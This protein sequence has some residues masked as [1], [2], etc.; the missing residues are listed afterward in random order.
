LGAPPSDS[1]RNCG[2][3]GFGAA[4]VAAASAPPSAERLPGGGLGAAGLL[5]FTAGMAAGFPCG[6]GCGCSK[7]ERPASPRL[8]LPR[9]RLGAMASAAARTPPSG[10]PLLPTLAALAVR[11]SGRPPPEVLASAGPHTPGWDPSLAPPA[12]GAPCPSPCCC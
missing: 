3:G 12:A 9:P 1:L 8:R 7:T 10:A 11:L 2:A 4:A 6:C 5:L